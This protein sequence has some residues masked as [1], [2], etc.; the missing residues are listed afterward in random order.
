MKTTT[1][2][3]YVL[4]LARHGLANMRSGPSLMAQATS[5]AG[6]NALLEKRAACEPGS[7]CWGGSC[8]GPGTCA[9]NCCGLDMAG[10]GVGCGLGESCEYAS[11]SV[12]IGCC[13]RLQIG[14]C[15]GTATTIT[16]STI[17]GGVTTT[18]E[19]STTTSREPSTSSDDPME[20]STVPTTTTRTPLPTATSDTSSS[21]SEGPIETSSTTPL[22]SSSTEEG[23]SSSSRTPTDDST[24]S[25]DTTSSPTAT[26]PETT[27]TDAAAVVDPNI[28]VVAGYY[29][30]VNK[31]G[32]E[33]L[34]P[35]YPFKLT[36][37]LAYTRFQIRKPNLIQ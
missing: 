25:D 9:Y 23:S 16:M 11:Q 27:E 35:K 18:D 30:L 29:S 34:L 1:T 7:I 5:P 15:V 14:T 22:I 33:P 31:S 24:A 19:P 13:D 12:F 17:Y 32:K 10:Q 20:T 21:G 6:A 37:P 36:P 4:S 26:I 3:L 2:L 28:W 8:C